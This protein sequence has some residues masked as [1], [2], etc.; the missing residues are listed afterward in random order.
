[1]R[2]TSALSFTD[3][4]P[5]LR[6]TLTSHH[7]SPLNLTATL[8]RTSTPHIGR[9]CRNG[10]MPWY[11]TQLTIA[12]DAL[13]RRSRIVDDSFNVFLERINFNAPLPRLHRYSMPPGAHVRRFPSLD[14][15]ARGLRWNVPPCIQSNLLQTPQSGS[16]LQ[17]SRSWQLLRET[18][19]RASKAKACLEAL[20][21]TDIIHGL[22]GA[23]LL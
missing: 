21:R 20:L 3:G 12:A 10:R 7:S 16:E 8:A 1:M 4:A 6:S 13:P 5:R 15:L 11:T 18:P 14:R 2:R 9:C 23:C 17:G 19:R 22:A